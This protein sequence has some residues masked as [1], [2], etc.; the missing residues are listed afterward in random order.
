MKWVYDDGGRDAAGYSGAADDCVCRS[1]AIATGLPYKHVYE[2]L[3]LAIKEF[4]RSSNSLA[5]LSRRGSSPANGVHRVVYH[6]YL[7]NLGAVWTP[8]MRIGQGCKVHLRGGELPMGRLVVRASKH[9]TAVID[10]VIHDTYDPGRDGT[11]CVYGYYT[12]RGESEPKG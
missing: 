4:R 10:G 3:R 7:L 1:I 2:S 8:T 9:I 5:A 12:L 6:P 11:R